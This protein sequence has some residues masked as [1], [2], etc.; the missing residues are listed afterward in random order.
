M[1]TVKKKAVSKFFVEMKVPLVRDIYNKI[2][3]MIKEVRDYY[4]E[5][6]ANRFDDEEITF[7]MLLD[8]AFLFACI[9]SDW[10][11]QNQG[12]LVFK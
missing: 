7:M 4:D 8:G 12:N 9:R 11:L 2:R 6:P 5:D 3:N 10:R 1:E